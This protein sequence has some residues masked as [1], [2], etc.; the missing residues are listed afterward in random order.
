MKKQ[1]LVCNC[2]C[3]QNLA[4]ENSFKADNILFQV[5]FIGHY[6]CYN[7]RKLV[8]QDNEIIKKRTENIVRTSFSVYNGGGII[9]DVRMLYQDS[10]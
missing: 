10:I 3:K 1:L 7:L 4:F 8:V 2:S 9:W 6:F 5:P